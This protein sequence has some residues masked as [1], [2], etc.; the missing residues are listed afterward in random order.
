MA[1]AEM[2]FR[3]PAMEAVVRPPDRWVFASETRDGGASAS[4]GIQDRQGGRRHQSCGRTTISPHLLQ[5]QAFRNVEIARIDGITVASH[6]FPLAMKQEAEEK[7][8]I[9]HGRVSYE[10]GTVAEMGFRPLTMEAMMHPADQC[11]FAGGT[12]DGGAIA[13]WG[14][15]D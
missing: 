2:S 13:S 4:R 9:G 12:G 3:P 11:I 5:S 7:I 1:V 14:I 10:N 8:R 6:S 15:Q